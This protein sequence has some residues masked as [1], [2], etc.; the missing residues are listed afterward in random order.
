MNAA[1]LEWVQRNVTPEE[2]H[3]RWVLE[4]GSGDI[5]GSVRPWFEHNQCEGYLGVD[6][7]PGPGV[8]QVVDCE[9]LT[10][11]FDVGAADIVLSCEMLEHV[12]DWS[13]CLAQLLLAVR[14]GGLLVLTTRSPG[15]PYHPYPEDHWRFTVAGT[16]WMLL[17]AG[18][19][20][21]L[22][23]SDPSEPGIFVKARKP[24]GWS[25]PGPQPAELWTN[26]QV[27]RIEKP[28]GADA[29]RQAGASAFIDGKWE[30]L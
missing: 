1:I 30:K 6:A 14:P 27:T 28:H 20:D 24:E 15:F 8:D 26:G 18:F 4:V 2:I 10:S 25:W 12:R 7:N 16:R 3:N 23:E 5:N 9:E 19:L 17:V 21:P 13:A 22:V 29:Y 11:A